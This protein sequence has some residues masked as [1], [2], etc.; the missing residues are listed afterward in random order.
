MSS[1][2]AWALEDI[3]SDLLPELESR[4]GELLS[5]LEGNRLL[6]KFKSEE[7]A[8]CGAVAI[9]SYIENRGIPGSLVSNN[10]RSAILIVGPEE[11]TT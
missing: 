9:N 3:R 7:N 11:L 1:H 5:R 4:F 8:I 2:H 6:F 10:G